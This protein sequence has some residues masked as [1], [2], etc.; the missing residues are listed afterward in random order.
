MRG[1]SCASYTGVRR[2]NIA[3]VRPPQSRIPSFCETL[4]NPSTNLLHHT[5][6]RPCSEQNRME[7]HRY[8]SGIKTPW[9]ICRATPFY[10][11]F[12]GHWDSIILLI[13]KL[14]MG[15][16]RLHQA[17]ILSV[18]LDESSAEGTSHAKP[19]T[20]PWFVSEY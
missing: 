3:S 1:T 2:S 18:A 10:R 19:R 7:N 12:T 4:T 9:H 16:Y 14:N 5:I 8:G 11:D 17:C 20:L 13:Y 15:H 6:H